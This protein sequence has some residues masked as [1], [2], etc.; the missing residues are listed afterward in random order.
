MLPTCQSSQNSPP[1]APQSAVQDFSTSSNIYGAYF[2]FEVTLQTIANS[3]GLALEKPFCVPRVYIGS[4]TTATIG[5]S[6]RMSTYTNLQ[7]LPKYVA[8][9]LNEGYT[10]THKGLLLWAPIPSAADVPLLRAMFILLEATL[11]VVFWVVMSKIGGWRL[12]CPWNRFTMFLGC[13]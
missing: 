8:A 9:A 6:H 12:F 5:V 4:G 11:T 13:R 2:P 10:I 3:G 1:P 7:V